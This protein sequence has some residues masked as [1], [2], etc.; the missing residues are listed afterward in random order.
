MKYRLILLSTLVMALAVLAGCKPGGLAGTLLSPIIDDIIANMSQSSLEALN[1]SMADINNSGAS[2]VSYH[3]Q[4]PGSW[5]QSPTLD[6]RLAI[7]SDRAFGLISADA[8]TVSCP[9]GGEIVYTDPSGTWNSDNSSFS[10]VRTFSNCGSPGGLFTVSGDSLAGW[11]NLKGAGV[12]GAQKIQ[13]GSV[14]NQ[15]P[16]GKRFT[17]A[18]NRY[19]ITVDG[20]DAPLSS[21]GLTGN[22]AHTITWTAVSD[23][24]RTFTINSN[25]TRKGFTAAGTNFFEH[26]VTTPAPVTVTAD[27]AGGTRTISGTVKVE[28]IL[29]NVVMTATMSGLVIPVDNC[30][31]SSGSATI[32]ITGSKTGSGS[33][34]YNSD[35]TATYSYTDSRGNTFSG[36]FTLCGCQ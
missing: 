7:A 24:S 18:T 29:S 3:I 25:L 1:D 20:N 12:Y 32:D 4:Y 14:M 34:T 23:T 8:A 31:P 9:G 2:G 21:G 36:N 13:T 19:Y 35:K 10:V 5:Q 6:E 11:S 27:T 15:A 26:R 28:Y 30:I 16:V 17:R 22:I 33:I